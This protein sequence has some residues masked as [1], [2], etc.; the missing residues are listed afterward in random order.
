MRA[1]FVGLKK[2][3]RIEDVRVELSWDVK[4]FLDVGTKLWLVVFC[5]G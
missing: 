2:P 3:R 1:I 5:L 4:S